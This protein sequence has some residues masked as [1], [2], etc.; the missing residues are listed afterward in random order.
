ML[1]ETKNELTGRVL[2][3][4]EFT[5]GEKS[6]FIGEKLMDL[7]M[8]EIETMYL[9]WAIHVIMPIRIGE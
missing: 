6:S 2:L 3:Y 8:K 9:E 4:D 7:I 1:V 5:K